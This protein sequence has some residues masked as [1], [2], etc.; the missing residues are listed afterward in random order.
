MIRPVDG[1]PMFTVPGRAEGILASFDGSAAHLPRPATLDG[2]CETATDVRALDFPRADVSAA[3]V[4][5]ST[6]L[7]AAGAALDNAKRLAEDDALVVTTGQ[8]PC[9]ALGPLYVIGKAVTAIKLA[10]DVAGRLG[11][12]VVPVYWNASEDHDIDEVSVAAAPG[13]DGG[14]A[15]FKADLDA[16]RGRPI[17]AVGADAA[18]Q[19]AARAWLRTLDASGAHPD[20]VEAL[21]PRPDETWARWFARGMSDLLSRHGLVMLEPQALRPFAIPLVERIVES[22]VAVQDLLRASIAERVE[23]SVA[24][25]FAD[26]DGPPLFVE[27]DGERRRV[28]VSDDGFTLRGEEGVLSRERLLETVRTRPGDVSSHAALRP[29]VQNAVLPVV[30]AVLGPGEIAYHEE[31]LRFHASDLGVRRRMPVLWPRASVTLID[32]RSRATMERFGVTPPDLFVPRDEFVSRF[33]PAGDLEG[34]VRDLA[35]RT[36]ASVDELRGAVLRL[37][38]TLERPFAKTVDAVTRA[39]STLGDKVQR[40]EATA[41]GFAPDKLGRLSAFVRPDGKPQERSFCGAWAVAAYG[42]GLVDELVSALDI[43]DRRHKIV[44]PGEGEVTHGG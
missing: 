27:R 24:A 4:E 1:I 44:T 23:S 8:Q 21:A 34:S 7:G 22:H 3:L 12:P 42:T 36:A 16:W 20:L 40:A 15:K 37:D 5:Y 19:E 43:H 6:S 2:V 31:L 29:I 41:G 9:A 25:S 17:A 11:V 28:H 38:P 26:L 35:R 32:E 33:T 39:L 18:W 14:L 13:R 10:R 30:A